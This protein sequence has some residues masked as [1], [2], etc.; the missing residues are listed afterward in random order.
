MVDGLDA[1]GPAPGF[2]AELAL[3]GQFVGSWELDRTEYT[4]DGRVAS[5]HKGEWHFGWVLGGRA[6]QDVWICPARGLPAPTGDSPGEWP[7]EWGTVI[8]FYDPILDAWRVTSHGP[9]TGV[10]ETFIGRAV[11]AE[12]VQIAQGEPMRWIFSDISDDRFRWRSEVSEEDGVTW[13]MNLEMDVRR[14]R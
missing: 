8:R 11:G 9:R 7:G 13:R 3:F 2:E 6:I 14:A 10:V 5:V 1:G 12:I 4:L